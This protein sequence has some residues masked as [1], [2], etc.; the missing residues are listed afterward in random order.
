MYEAGYKNTLEFMEIAHMSDLFETHC[1]HFEVKNIH[2]E[3]LPVKVIFTC[4]S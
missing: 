2:Q 1:P 4:R 3:N